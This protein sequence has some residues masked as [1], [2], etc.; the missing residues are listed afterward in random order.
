MTA[1]VGD[2][3]RFDYPNYPQYNQTLTVVKVDGNDPEDR[4]TFDNEGS[5]KQTHLAWAISQ[6]VAT[7]L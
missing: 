1:K 2:V 7:K 3:F 5:C 4:V 6:K